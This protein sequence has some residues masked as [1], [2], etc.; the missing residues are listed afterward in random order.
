MPLICNQENMT[1]L[2][3]ALESGKYKQATGTLRDG[4]AF[5]CLGVA[6][7]ISGLGKW[8]PDPRTGRGSDYGFLC[9]ERGDV[10]AAVLPKSVRVWLGVAQSQLELNEWYGGT[11]T[12]GMLSASSLNDNGSSFQQIAAKIREAYGL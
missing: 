6:C 11:S 4:E 1:K 10:V 5:C 7:D 12:K 3:K 8:V 9:S 2:V